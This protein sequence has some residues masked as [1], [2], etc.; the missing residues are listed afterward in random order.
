VPYDSYLFLAN[1]WNSETNCNRAYQ[2]ICWITIQAT[3][4]QYHSKIEGDSTLNAIFFSLLLVLGLLHKTKI[5]YLFI[6]NNQGGDKILFDV[7]SG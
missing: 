6:Y 3:R 2:V 5:S 1:Q 7:I 4:N